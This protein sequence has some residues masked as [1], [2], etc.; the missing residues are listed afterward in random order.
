[1]A[2]ATKRTY[3]L[4]DP[5]AKAAAIRLLERGLITQTEAAQLAGVNRQL[6]RFWVRDID[7][8]AAREAV[9]V[10]LWQRAVRRR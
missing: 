6:V 2:K 4:A 7:L 1:M 10:R 9:L 8:E 3:T 5:A